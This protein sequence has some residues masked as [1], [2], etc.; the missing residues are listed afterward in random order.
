MGRSSRSPDRSDPAKDGKT[1]IQAPQPMGWHE[2]PGLDVPPSSRRSGS[3]SPSPSPRRRSR[4]R[5]GSRSGSRSRS[6][7]SP[8]P[9]PRAGGTNSLPQGHNDE[10][11]ICHFGDGAC[12]YKAKDEGSLSTHR[13]FHTELRLP[14]IIQVSD[15][16]DRLICQ[17]W[18]EN[19]VKPKF[20]CPQK[21]CCRVTGARHEAEKHH[22]THIQ[23]KDYSAPWVVVKGRNVKDYRDSPYSSMVYFCSLS[24]D[25]EYFTTSPN[26]LKHHYLS[27]NIEKGPIEHLRSRS[28]VTVGWGENSILDFQCVRCLKWLPGSRAFDQHLRIHKLVEHWFCPAYCLSFAISKDD[29]QQHMRR[30]HPDE[31]SIQLNNEVDR[32]FHIYRCE[33]CKNY[34]VF[35]KDWFKNH[36]IDT[37]GYERRDQITVHKKKAIQLHKFFMMF[38][39][40]HPCL[41][42]GTLLQTESER[43]KHMKVDGNG[44]QI[45]YVLPLAM[46]R[47]CITVMTLA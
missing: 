33:L 44:M 46:I 30:E 42:C 8:S 45:W 16:R 5:S 43:V 20:V 26:F 36:L 6:S 4:S 38:T 12:K 9:S 22:N 24:E 41:T 1:S 7:R 31:E 10:A 40:K 15:K 18:T 32:Q 11:W 23:N 17:V 21:G 28:F 35:N 47:G 2:D 27:K 3:G 37:H 14:A 13:T 25:C 34:E 29:L 39:A 19:E